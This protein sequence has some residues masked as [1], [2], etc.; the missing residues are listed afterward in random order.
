MSQIQR[1]QEK[2]YLLDLGELLRD[3]IRERAQLGANVVETGHEGVHFVIMRLNNGKIVSSA[4]RKRYRF[5]L[6]KS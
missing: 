1:D 4:L 2:G 6:D 5:A 3:G